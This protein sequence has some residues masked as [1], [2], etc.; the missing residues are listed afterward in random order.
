MKNTPG[1]PKS[2]TIELLGHVPAKKNTTVSVMVGKKRRTIYAAKTYTE[3]DRLAM[4]IPGEARDI[5][6]LHPEIDFYMTTVD[7]RSDRDNAVT[8]CLDLLVLYGVLSNDTIASCNNRITI[9]PAK[10]GE[11]AKTVIVLTENTSDAE[12]W[13]SD[14]NPYRY[15]RRKPAAVKRIRP[16]QEKRK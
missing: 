16:S 7:G 6:L 1:Y 15:I 8:S 11:V 5:H 4:Q 2:W 14:R 10:K 3:L 13:A 9:H 12:L